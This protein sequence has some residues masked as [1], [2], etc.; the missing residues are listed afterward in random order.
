MTTSLNNN[1]YLI[2]SKNRSL[3]ATNSLN[4]CETDDCQ[5]SLLEDNIGKDK[6]HALET[7]RNMTS[8]SSASSP[9]VD[10]KKNVEASSVNK[11][12]ARIECAHKTIGYLSDNEEEEEI[13]E[14]G[15]EEN[16]QQDRREAYEHDK[17]TQSDD[18][19]ELDNN[20][21]DYVSSRKESRFRLGQIENRTN[22]TSV[23]N[24]EVNRRSQANGSIKNSDSVC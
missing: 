8:S 22:N 10:S 3:S 13:E 7:N 11:N 4:D 2:D 24:K 14:E 5:P 21:N 23:N 9:N 1:N 18:S 17:D 6:L 15:D 12:I 20:R 16:S 19:I